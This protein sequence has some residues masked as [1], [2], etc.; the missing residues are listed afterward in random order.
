MALAVCQFF[1]YLHK[2][3]SAFFFDD[4]VFSFLRGKLRIHVYKLFCGDKCN[5]SWKNFFYVVI[6][7]CHVFL[8]LAEYAVDST[9]SVNE[10]F[11]ISLFFGDD[12]LPV[13]LVYI[14][15]MDVVNILITADG[16]HIGV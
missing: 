2:E 13:P 4:L 11:Y 8:C 9:D 12:L 6:L 5:L 14:D 7:Y 16:N 10:S 3:N 15:G 1:T